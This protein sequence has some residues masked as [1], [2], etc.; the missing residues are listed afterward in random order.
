LSLPISLSFKL[1]S[2]ADVAML[3]LVS[4]DKTQTLA[5][6]NDGG[7]KFYLSAGTMYGDFTYQTTSAWDFTQG[8]TNK[9]VYTLDI[10]ETGFVV[11]KIN[12]V[13]KKQFQ[14][15]I[16]DYRLV[17]SSN[18]TYTVP[19]T[20][21]QLKDPTNNLQKLACTD[22]D[23]D[24]DGIPNRIDTDSDG[25]GCYDAVEAGT[26]AVS[27]SGV[28]SANKLTAAS[29]PSP[30]G[31]NGF[32]NGLETSAESGVYNATYSYDLAINASLAACT[33]TD[34]DGVPNITDIDDDNDGTTDFDEDYPL[35]STASSYTWINWSVIQPKVALGTITS[36]GQTINVTVRHDAGGLSQTGNI[37]NGANFPVAYGLAV[38]GATLAS[39]NIGTISVSF[40]Q[41]V[42]APA[43]AYA[44]LGNSNLGVPVT[45]SIPF[46]TEWAG[47]NTVYN[48][49]N[50]FT[51]SDGY[52]IVTLK[53][54]VS[55]F[56][57]QHSVFENYYNIIFGLKDITKCSGT[58]LD[59][60]RDGIPNSQDLDADGDGCSDAKEAGATAC[61]L[62]TSDAADDGSIV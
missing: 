34:N 29:I 51:G 10:S 54:N 19:F 2:V 22:I 52:N 59:T 47:M 15:L 35:C 56:T 43:I 50:Q 45:T 14:G 58:K 18:T 57:L 53:G 38:N 5:N 33:D 12:G 44:S 41:P 48:S 49:P 25:D 31:A 21:I 7:Y 23:T 30:W 11:A 13:V 16:S 4:V 60:D 8:V 37:S 32:A 20:E 17:V 36:G 40:S 62:Y 3:G 46:K 9:D 1:G 42:G 27:T 24:S 61:L 55:N 39:Q 28:A 26:T 6:W